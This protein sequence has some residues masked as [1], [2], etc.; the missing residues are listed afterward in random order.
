MDVTLYWFALRDIGQDHKVFVHLL[1][2]DGQ[3]AA[4]HDGDP[5]GGFTPTSRWRQGELIRDRHRLP[6][7]PGLA[8]GPVRLKAGMYQVEPM[9]NL[10][11]DPPTEDGRID[12]GE[13]SL[14]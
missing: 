12:L 14:K 13:V 8:A 5:V 7:P 6:I 11:L 3:V 1:G 10:P 9:A 4:Q 2:P